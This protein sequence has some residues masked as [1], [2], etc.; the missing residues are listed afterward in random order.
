M[1]EGKIYFSPDIS[2]VCSELVDYF[3]VTVDFIFSQLISST[4]HVFYFPF[5]FSSL[6]INSMNTTEC[7]L[8]QEEQVHIQMQKIHL[9]QNYYP[10][11]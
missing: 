9:S 5:S 10:Q 6:S 2:N 8:L 3:P 11:F 7:E 4:Y 1:S